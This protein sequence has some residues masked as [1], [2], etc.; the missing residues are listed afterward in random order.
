MVTGLVAS[1]RWPRFGVVM[2]YSTAGVS[3]VVGMGLS[4][5]SYAR[6][7]WVGSLPA[8]G[9]SQAMTLLAMVAFGALL[10]WRIAPAKKMPK[11]RQATPFVI[12]D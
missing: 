8:K 5:I 10:Q 11:A 4:A 2:L 6:P 12:D 9:S 1:L 7:Q 3:L